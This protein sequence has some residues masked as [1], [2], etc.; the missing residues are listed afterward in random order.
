MVGGN[1]LFLIC[2]LLVLITGSKVYGQDN[3]IYF[4]IKAGANTGKYYPKVASNNY[5][6]KF[7]FYAGGFLSVPLE[8]GFKFQPELLFALQGTKVTV[9]GLKIPFFDYMGR[10]I[11][12]PNTYEFKYD[13]NELTIAIPLMVKLYLSKNLYL[14]SGPQIGIIVD[15]RL[16]SSYQVLDGED[17]SFIAREGG[18]FDLGVSFG[19][20]H[21]L[22]DKIALNL[23]AFT[24][25]FKRDD[26]VPFVFNLGLE[27]KL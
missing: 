22:N 24:G 4:G 2:V 23:R 21:N 3:A 20:G 16:T 8:E 27:Y 1:S 7:G 14:E 25:I 5:E 11:P 18:S 6:F 13:I 9:D 15:R 12:N 26:I 17:D 10:P 19:V